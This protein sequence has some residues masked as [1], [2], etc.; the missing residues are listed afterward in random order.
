[1]VR[2]KEG[3]Q[4]YKAEPAT[5]DEQRA[6]RASANRV[7]TMLKAALNLAYDDGKVPDNSAWGSGRNS[8]SAELMSLWA[9]A[10][11]R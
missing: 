8:G 6:R 2:S 7:L 11:L 10:T 3:E 4:R 1:M 5:E 9:S